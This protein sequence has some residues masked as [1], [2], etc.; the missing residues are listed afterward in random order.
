MYSTERGA[1]VILETV[2]SQ[3]RVGQSQ[4]RGNQSGP[5]SSKLVVKEHQSYVNLFIRGIL[6]KLL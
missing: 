4:C 2:Q 1:T 3:S 6:C 5:I